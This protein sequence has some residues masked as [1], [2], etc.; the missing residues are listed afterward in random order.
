M[1]S[2]NEVIDIKWVI[3]VLNENLDLMITFMIIRRSWDNTKQIKRERI[4]FE[5]F[6]WKARKLRNSPVTLKSLYLGTS[7]SLTVISN[8]RYMRWEKS[9]LTFNQKWYDILMLLKCKSLENILWGIWKGTL[10]LFIGGLNTLWN[11]SRNE[12]MLYFLSLFW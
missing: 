2:M 9:S 12:G 1:G 6:V 10:Y 8:W 7:T 4:L 3:T 11:L 5:Q